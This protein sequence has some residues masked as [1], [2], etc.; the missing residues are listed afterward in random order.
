MLVN[1]TGGG[2]GFGDPME[3]DFDA[4]VKDVRN[5]Y[6]SREAVQ[7]DYGVVVT[8]EFTVD[9]AATAALRG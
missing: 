8:P 4:I 1:A 2:S 6:V 9:E 7:R 3:R 5:G